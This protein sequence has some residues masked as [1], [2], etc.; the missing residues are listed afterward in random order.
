MIQSA[1]DLLLRLVPPS[2]KRQLGYKLLRS[3]AGE[4]RAATELF[5]FPYDRWRDWRSGLGRGRFVLYGLVRCMQPKTIVEIGSS[6]GL[7]T[8]TLALGCRHNGAGRVY[9][10]DPHVNNAW[11]D[12]GTHGTT[13]TFLGDR[14]R[15]YELEPYCQVMTMTSQ[16]IA[17]TWSE[18]IDL[19]FIDGDHTY[20]GVKYDFEAFAPWLTRH[21]VVLFH[22]SMWEHYRQDANYRTDIGVPR[23]L[24]EL[25]RRGYQTV[26]FP[27]V[28]GLTLMS[29]SRGHFPFLLPTARGPEPLAAE[30]AT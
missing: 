8:C 29:A 26:T 13:L 2:V 16:E 23:Y 25:Q 14:L 20:E 9:A 28:P 15:D 21:A 6:R 17:E 11:T 3:S 5:S 10:I 19:L 24:D 12:R 22:D 27:D 18:P 30:M 1:C 7:S 4:F